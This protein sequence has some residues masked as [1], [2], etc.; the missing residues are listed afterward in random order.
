MTKE[1]K[2][3][4]FGSYFLADGM[5]R[6]GKDMRRSGRNNDGE[7]Y[8][9]YRQAARIT[10]RN[11]DADIVDWVE[12]NIGGHVFF[13]AKRDR[14]WNEK[15]GKYYHPNPTAIWQAE[16]L[17]DCVRVCEIMLKSPIPGK[18]K[19]EAK[20]FLEYAQVKKDNY[21]RGKKYPPE[22]M[23]KFDKYYQKMKDLKKFK[24]K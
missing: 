19:K 16:A 6:I 4:A 5:I 20:L 17:D 12:D 7:K 8:P 18:K 9:W 22:A 13:H 24:E 15:K 3:I 23:K 2:E 21:K 14:V 1:K 10:V 11:D